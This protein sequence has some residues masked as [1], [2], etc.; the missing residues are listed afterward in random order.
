MDARPVSC[1]LALALAPLAAFA[2]PPAAPPGCS[3]DAFT[4]DAAPVGVQICLVSEAPHG[5]GPGKPSSVAL[6]ET[7]SSR[8]ATF[9]RRVS[10]EFFSGGDYSR[11]IDDVPLER[12]GL[13]RTLHLTIGYKPGSVRLEHALLVP[14]AI[15]LK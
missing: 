11:T 10:L 6:D 9:S 8:G 15:A 7:L 4:I 12:F 5:T 13:A 1:A 3:S 14:G 2:A